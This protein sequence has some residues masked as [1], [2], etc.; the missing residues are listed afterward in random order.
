MAKNYL[1]I[2]LLLLNFGVSAQTVS[3]TSFTNNNGSGTVT[4]NLQN[5]NGYDVIITEVKGVTGASGTQTAA[6][7]YK[8]T[9][10]SGAPG[11]ISTAN[12][13][14]QGPSGTYTG[15]SNTSTS[16]VQ[17]FLSGL[18]FILPANTT[19][20]MAITSPSQRYST[21]PAGTT[22]FSA[23]GVNF[24]TGTNIGYGGGTPPAAPG[25]SPR[26]WIGQITFMPAC[27]N[28][29]NVVASN[30][31][32]T[33]VDF[34]WTAVPSS[35]GYEYYVDQNPTGT[36]T[37]TPTLVTNCHISGL[38]INTSYYFHVRNKC[39][40]AFS[41]WTNV[42]FTTADAYCKPP[43]NVLF[44]SVT[45]N[46][47]NVLWSSTPN[48][49]SYDYKY[50]LVKVIPASKPSLNTTGITATLTGLQPGT[51]YYFIVRSVCL[52]GGDSSTWKLDSFITKDNCVAPELVLS[53]PGD[54]N[55]HVYWQPVPEAVAYEYRLSGSMMDPAFGTEISA[56]MVTVTLPPGNDDQYLHVRSKCN[57]QFTFSPWSMIALRMVAASVSN[58]ATGQNVVLYP[59]P[60]ENVLLVK[61]ATGN[62]YKISDMLGHSLRSG[63]IDVEE[64]AVDLTGMAAG[65]YLL[66]IED[67]ANR[68]IFR[69]TKK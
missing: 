24:I 13:W 67:G 45:T 61:F 25:N 55:P 38:T 50:D 1:V 35:L 37:G 42:P 56:P 69:F 46:S 6:I 64:L 10:L 4:F 19:Y 33:D 18:N 30:I 23:G 39:A 3:S 9:P 11:A 5:T 21:I 53:N 51:K 31:T 28:P 29:T 7:W 15:I 57:S 16:V 27:F 63:K 40:S 58:T 65:I 60:A 12:G 52:N 49:T 47:V 59:N 62:N 22:T 14:I 48:A 32:T 8:T 26:G 68:Q 66:E 17:T 43:V 36:G 34:N 20:A 54:N 41:S 2:L 44:N